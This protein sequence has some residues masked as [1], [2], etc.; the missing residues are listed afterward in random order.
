M[1][2]LW[3]KMRE[4]EMYE[5]EFGIPQEPIALDISCPNCMKKKLEF[6]NAHDIKCIAQGCGQEFVLVD[7]QTVRFK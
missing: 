6:H 7:A 1:K 2:A 5:A 3:A 4:K